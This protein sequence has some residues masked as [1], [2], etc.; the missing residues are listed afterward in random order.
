MVRHHWLSGHELEQTPRDSE[1][2]EAWRAA[3]HGSQR[4]RHDLVTEEQHL[5]WKKKLA[6]FINLYIFCSLSGSSFE[7]LYNVQQDLF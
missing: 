3:V 6:N 5:K 7:G 2:Q 1:G 4:V